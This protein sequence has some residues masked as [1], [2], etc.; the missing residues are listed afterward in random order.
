MTDLRHKL[1]SSGLRTNV[2]DFACDL[3][4]LTEFED[5]LPIPTAVSGRCGLE[6]VYTYGSHTL[7]LNI[8]EPGYYHFT[9]AEDGAEVL[10]G[11]VYGTE[12]IQ[13]LR[14]LFFWLW[15]EPW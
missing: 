5:R 1:R 9:A 7:I 6:L 10:N 3:L 11:G 2:V 8:V 13:T 12:L 14:N 15:N 4:E